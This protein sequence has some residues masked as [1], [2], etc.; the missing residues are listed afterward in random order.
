MKI[1]GSTWNKLMVQGYQLDR[2]QGTL[3]PPVKAK[4][5][6]ASATPSPASRVKARR[7]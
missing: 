7:S 6:S 1:H 4:H 2:Q 3:T 5:G